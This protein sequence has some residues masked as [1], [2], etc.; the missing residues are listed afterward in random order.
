MLEQ[1]EL[2]H[3]H[4]TDAD[5]AHFST[6]T[7]LRCLNLSGNSITPVGLRHLHNLSNLERLYLWNNKDLQD[8]DVASLQMALP[9]C[10]IESG[11]ILANLRT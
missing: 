6:S 4:L 1:L 5:L 3:L 10:T 2:A 8:S 7:N 9:M 11:D